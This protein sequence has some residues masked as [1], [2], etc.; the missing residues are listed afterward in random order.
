MKE[1]TKHYIHRF[2][3][4]LSTPVAVLIALV[5][6]FG[7]F[8]V[9]NYHFEKENQQLIANTKKSVDNS[10]TIIKNLQQAVKDLKTDNEHQTRFISCLLALQGRPDLVA[11]DVQAQCTKMSSH[12]DLQ[13][14][15][16][17]KATSTQPQTTP[18][19]TTQSAPVENKPSPDNSTPASSPKVLDCKVDVLFVHIG[20]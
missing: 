1:M 18:V 13:D 16:R 17:V 4:F 6:M 15:T 3:A 14:V 10:S 8:A 7:Y 2:N 19:S 5:L 12:V 9:G 11:A 20:C